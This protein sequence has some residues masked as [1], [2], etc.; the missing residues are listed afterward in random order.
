MIVDGVAF[1]VAF[2]ALGTALAGFGTAA[3][4]FG[5]LAILVLCVRYS[6]QTNDNIEFIYRA[7]GAAA[8]VILLATFAVI[9]WNGGKAQLTDLFPGFAVT[10]LLVF[11][12]GSAIADGTKLSI[13]SPAM[14]AVLMTLFAA[15]QIPVGGAMLIAMAQLALLLVD[16][17]K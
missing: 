6:L 14:V 5:L 16:K 3:A 4:A 15:A 1:S 10:A 9:L 2:A 11:S 7:I 13:L 8:W 17:S 12:R